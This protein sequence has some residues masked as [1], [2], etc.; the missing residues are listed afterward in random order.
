MVTDA[1][2]CPKRIIKKMLLEML[3]CTSVRAN[4]MNDGRLCRTL[5]L[6]RL[7]HVLRL[8]A[9]HVATESSIAS[10]PSG[11]CVLRL[12]VPHVETEQSVASVPSGWCMLHFAAAHSDGEH[13][14]HDAVCVL[15]AL[16]L[17]E[18]SLDTA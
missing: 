2:Q 11:Q 6:S 16:Q 3:V 8:V 18:P 7:S 5:Q 4:G 15:Q 1:A 17:W 9:P 12:V 13:S 14:R 10:V